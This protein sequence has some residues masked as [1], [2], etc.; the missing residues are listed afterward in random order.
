MF[1]YGNDMVLSENEKLLWEREMFMYGYDM[2]LVYVLLGFML[3]F[4]IHV[5]LFGN[6][7]LLLEMICS[8]SKYIG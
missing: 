7:M 6:G 2:S 1:M 3:L 4:G 5:F 8:C